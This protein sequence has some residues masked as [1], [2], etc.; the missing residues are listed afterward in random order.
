[1]GGFDS[2]VISIDN[3]W[4]KAKLLIAYNFSGGHNCT[5]QRVVPV[6][7]LM[8][9]YYICL[10]YAF[11]LCH[12]HEYIWKSTRSV[13]LF[14]IKGGYINNPHLW[15]NTERICSALSSI[16]KYDKSCTYCCYERCATFIA[17]VGGIPW[18]I[19]GVTQYH[20]C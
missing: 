18:P 11:I 14:I 6:Y 4:Y 10:I 8:H 19:T 15:R 7:R 3:F 13:N 1:M 2:F 17:W 12:G 20:A 9:C 16:L 5:S